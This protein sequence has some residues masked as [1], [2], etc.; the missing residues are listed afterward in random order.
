MQ[1]GVFGYGVYKTEPGFVY[2]L[3]GINFPQS[4]PLS[5][6]AD[7]NADVVVLTAVLAM[8]LLRLIEPN[9][10]PILALSL[11]DM[12]VACTVGAVV[13]GCVTTGG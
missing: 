10:R 2:L 6:A 9:N 1:V 11:L 5:Q 13:A 3:F 4:Y 7:F 12:A 8:F